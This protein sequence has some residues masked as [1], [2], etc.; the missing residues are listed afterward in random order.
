MKSA[1]DALLSGAGYLVISKK[2]QGLEYSL[3]KG[4]GVRISYSVPRG[5]VI[6]K[7]KTALFFFFFFLLI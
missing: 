3:P 2:A 1:T 6:M 7:I 4:T 5:T